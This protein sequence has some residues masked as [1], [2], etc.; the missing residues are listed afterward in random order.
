MEIRRAVVAG[1]H[2]LAIDQERRCLDAVGS[3]NDGRE[4]VAP[5]MAAFG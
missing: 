3:V 1:D 4:A 5:V 2:G